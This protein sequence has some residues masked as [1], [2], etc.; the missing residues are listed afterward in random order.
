MNVFIHL[1]N[2][3]HREKENLLGNNI[4]I[5]NEKAPRVGCV[6]ERRRSRDGAGAVAAAV[7]ASSLPAD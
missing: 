5:K 4:L 2:H 7:V 3:Q 6:E 1:I